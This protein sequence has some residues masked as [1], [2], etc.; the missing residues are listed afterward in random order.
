MYLDN[1]FIIVIIVLSLLFS[2]HV[3]QGYLFVLAGF[4][5]TIVVRNIFLLSL[6]LVTIYNFS[7]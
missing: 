3:E 4:Y 6:S 5:L 1:T 7:P 2:V